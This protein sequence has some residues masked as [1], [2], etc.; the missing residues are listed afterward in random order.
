[1]NNHHFYTYF[2]KWTKK[3]FDFSCNNVSEMYAND[4]IS[5]LRPAIDYDPLY[6]KVVNQ[7]YVD[8]LEQKL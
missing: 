8:H 7:K 6:F 2:A 3:L 1:M 4:V 5:N